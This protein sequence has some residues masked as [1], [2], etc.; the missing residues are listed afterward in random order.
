LVQSWNPDSL[1]IYLAVPLT[2]QPDE[3]RVTLVDLTPTALRALARRQP[4]SQ[5]IRALCLARLT[6]DNQRSWWGDVAESIAAAEIIA[7]EFGGDTELQPILEKQ[8]ESESLIAFIAIALLEGH[9][10]PRLAELHRAAHEEYRGEQ[11]LAATCAAADECGPPARQP[12]VSDFIETLDAG[13]TFGQT[14]RLRG[15]LVTVIFHLGAS[16][17]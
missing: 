16:F 11:R 5:K 10:H 7:Q 9:E 12:A 14:N 4:K 13:G 8:A 15:G 1:V 6:A 17:H 3:V 2:Q